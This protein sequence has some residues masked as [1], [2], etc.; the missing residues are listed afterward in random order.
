MTTA[1]R[2]KLDNLPATTSSSVAATTGAATISGAKKFF[3]GTQGQD[4]RWTLESLTP[5][6]MQKCAYAYLAGAT[7]GTSPAHLQGTDA[8]GN[9]QRIT[10]SDL[11]SL[12]GV[13]IT[14]FDTAL[15]DNNPSTKV[16]E[17]TRNIIQGQFVIIEVVAVHTNDGFAYSR[18]I[19]SRWNTDYTQISGEINK[20]LLTIAY[21]G[22]NIYIKFNKTTYGR[23]YLKSDTERPLQYTIVSAIPSDATI[24]Q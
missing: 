3:V 21:K 12:L 4:G 1:K 7:V 2:E 16:I 22:D 6:E 5:D 14:G 10:P 20:E 15:S 9:P 18:I 17:I 19:S 11:A 24:V 13:Y 8:S 23:V